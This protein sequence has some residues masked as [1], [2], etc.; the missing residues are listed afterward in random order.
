MERLIEKYTDTTCRHPEHNPATMIV[1]KP[2]MY[3][4]ECPRCGE[5]QQFEVPLITL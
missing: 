2:G 3:E 4:H 1:R 5:K